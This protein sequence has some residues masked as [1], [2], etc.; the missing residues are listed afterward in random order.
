M[1]LHRPRHGDA[2]GV[3]RVQHVAPH[4][5]ARRVGP[6][7]PRPHYR[8]LLHAP[9]AAAGQAS[10]HTRGHGGAGLQRGHAG[11]G[12]G[13]GRGGQPGDEPAAEL[14]AAAAEAEDPRPGDPAHLHQVPAG[15]GRGRLREGVQGRAGG[16]GGRPHHAGRH[17][18]AQAGRQPE[19]EERLRAGVRADDGPAPPQHRL[20]HRGLHA[21]DDVQTIKYV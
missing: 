12:R 6:Y 15:A 8:P 19:D 3:R 18:D 10:D 21:G 11:R 5:R 16:L 17:Q 1:V 2:G 4:R 7:Y 9:R 20:P 14:A 13:G